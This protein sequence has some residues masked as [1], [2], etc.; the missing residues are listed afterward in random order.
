MEVCG[1]GGAGSAA[2]ASARLDVIVAKQ[3]PECSAGR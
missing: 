3:E 1:N 2:C